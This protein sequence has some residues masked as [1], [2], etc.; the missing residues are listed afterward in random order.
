ML[1]KRRTPSLARPEGAIERRFGKEA[2]RRG[3]SYLKVT[4][5]GRRGIPDRL[6]IAPASPATYI[7]IEWKAPGGRLSALQEEVIKSLRGLGAH[8]LIEDTYEEAIRHVEALL[9]AK[10]AAD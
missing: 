2:E 3:W 6:I 8:V 10:S 5:P 7:W 9:G 4:T 1:S